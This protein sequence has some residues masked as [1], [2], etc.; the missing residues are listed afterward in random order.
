MKTDAGISTTYPWSRTID[1]H[2]L[3]FR[4]MNAADD[5]TMKATV[6]R[7]TNSLSD[8]D[9]AFLRMDIT[10]PEVVDEWIEN[11]KAGRTVTVLVE[12]GEEVFGYGNLHFS[13]L[14][15]TGHIA[16]I[17]IL[18]GESLRGLGI[19]RMLVD[20]LT[21]IAHGAGLEKVVAQIPSTQ[22]KVRRM[23]EDLGF[24][25]VALLTDWLKDRNRI[26]H[27]LIIMARD[28]VD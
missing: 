3:T 17:R 10:Q 27:D 7:F 18:V 4:L 14:Q 8:H 28:T 24:E 2:E 15:W 22:P 13:Q 1:G 26:T 9:I 21:E 12:R 6:L 23:F 11:I 20:A 19:G 16:E 5:E 25:P